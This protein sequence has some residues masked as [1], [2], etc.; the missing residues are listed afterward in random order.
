MVHIENAVSQGPHHAEQM[1]ALMLD[2]DA[3]KKARKDYDT[4]EGL[5]ATLKSSPGALTAPVDATQLGKDQQRLGEALAAAGEKLVGD[6]LR[7][8]DLSYGEMKTRALDIISANANSAADLFGIEP[9]TSVSN[10]RSCSNYVSAKGY[11]DMASSGTWTE[12]GN[13]LS[14]AGAGDDLVPF[15]GLGAVLLAGG[16]SF[17]FGRDSSKALRK[18]VQ[19]QAAA[20]ALAPVTIS[21]TLNAPTTVSAPLRLKLKPGAAP[22]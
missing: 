3:L 5:Q 11:N 21:L 9:G 4:V 17:P 22:P 16:C 12:M 8:R 15:F 6:F 2:T 10:I 14:T 18:A 13:C 20:D 1:Q 7:A 19:A